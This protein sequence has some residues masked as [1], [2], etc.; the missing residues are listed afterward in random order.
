MSMPM[1][2]GRPGRVEPA[3][4]AEV[5]DEIALDIEALGCGLCLDP[6]LVAAHGESLQAIDRLAQTMAA[7]AHV[8]RSACLDS[9]MAGVALEDLRDKLVAAHARVD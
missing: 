8:M 5:L 2:F 4:V 6:A 3:L 9:A 7:L 1:P